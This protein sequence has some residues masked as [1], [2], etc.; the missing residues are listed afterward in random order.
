[1]RTPLGWYLAVARRPLGRNFHGFAYGLKCLYYLSPLHRMAISGRVPDGL[2]FAPID[3]WPGNAERGR[4]I[5]AG[6]FGFAGHSVAMGRGGTP[7]QDLAF[8]GGTQLWD[9]SGAG[10]D[11]RAGLHGFGWLRDLRVAGGDG[12]RA[13]TRALIT[14]WIAH[15][16]RWRRLAWRPDILAARITAWIFS[17][18]FICQNA[19]DDFS[20]LFMKSL[21]RQARHLLGAGAGGLTGARRLAMLKGQIFASVALFGGRGRV[22][23]LQRFEK[24]LA[25]QVLPDGGHVER[26]PSQQ[27]AVLRDLVDIREL[28]MEAGFEVPHGIQ[29]AIDRM[30]PMLR[31][32]RHGDGG[33]V[34]FNDSG[35]EEAWLIDMA[36]TRA[37]APGKP[38]ISAPH[39]G[40]ERIHAGRTMIIADV[41][42]PPPP[43]ARDHTFAGSL[44]FEMSVGKERM[45]VNCGGGPGLDAAWRQGLRATAAHSTLTL[46]ETNSTEIFEAPGRG[47]EIG[48]HPSHVTRNRVASD[49]AVWLTGHHDGYVRGFGLAH[50]RRLWLADNGEDLRG[51]DALLPPG[52]AS[53][54]LMDREYDGR[55]PAIWRWRRGRPRVFHL[56]FHLHPRI[57]ASLV[58]DGAAVLLRLPSGAGWRFQAEGGNV[59]V[60]DSIYVGGGEVKRSSQIVVSGGV[61]AGGPRPGALVRWAFRREKDQR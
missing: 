5:M 7:H 59:S 32:F 48:K 38:L 47:S 26:S 39:S 57:V 2:G 43:G 24:A 58:Q 20:S 50:E 25:G 44:A 36:L 52:T 18:D 3:P 4:A 40:F 35:E 10:Q 34:L 30:A 33:L 41:G 1:M 42:T 49:G 9:A 16:G 31:F 22:R 61:T 12:A 54:A 53:A 46:A 29:I 21:T 56:R 51:E 28:L 55:K 6:H 11:W 27:L 15:S 37:N 60:Q 8:G 45:V 17:A 23:I 19:G 14:D 13:T